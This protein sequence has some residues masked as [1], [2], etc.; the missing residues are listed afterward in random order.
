MSHVFLNI[1]HFGSGKKCDTSCPAR[2]KELSQ[3]Q[4]IHFQ[5]KSSPSSTVFCI[6]YKGVIYQTYQPTKGYLSNLP[7]KTN[8]NLSQPTSLPPSLGEF[9]PRCAMVDQPPLPLKA[10]RRSC[11]SSSGASEGGGSDVNVK[12]M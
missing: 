7:N 9:P 4:T 6:S 11:C 5:Q 1:T 10:P 8:L 2:P 12:V 3:N